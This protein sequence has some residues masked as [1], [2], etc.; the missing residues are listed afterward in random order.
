M[1]SDR[2]GPLKKRLN[3]PLNKPLNNTLNP[4]LNNPK[5]TRHA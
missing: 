1:N 5:S 2:A 4:R 3:K